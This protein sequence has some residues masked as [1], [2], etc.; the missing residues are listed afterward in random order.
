M[1]SAQAPTHLDLTSLTGGY[2]YRNFFDRPIHPLRHLLASQLSETCKIH[3]RT[4][5]ERCPTRSL[6]NRLLQVFALVSPLARAFF[7]NF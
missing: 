5:F 6:I 2:I 3:T 7:R 4:V 1:T